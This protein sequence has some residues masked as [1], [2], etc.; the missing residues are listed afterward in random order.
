MLQGNKITSGTRNSPGFG[1]RVFGA[2]SKNL[3]LSHSEREVGGGTAERPCADE[4]SLQ[5]HYGLLRLGLKM[6]MS[7]VIIAAGQC[8]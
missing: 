6:A 8:A 7:R 1:K 3:G 4:S 5:F 2:S